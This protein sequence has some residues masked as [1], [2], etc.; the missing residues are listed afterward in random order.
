MSLPIIEV[1]KYSVTIPSTGDK[2]QYRP[3][4]VKEEKILMIAMESESQE[5]M[6][7][8]IRDIIDACTFNTLDIDSLSTFDLEYIFLKLRAKSVGEV[9]TVGLK[10]SSCSEVNEIDINLDAIEVSFPE[11]APKNGVVM[12]ND[13]IGIRFRYPTVANS[14]KIKDSNTIEGI[15]KLITLCIDNIFDAEN[16]YPASNST[17]KELMAFLESLNTEQFARIQ[18]FFE[19]MPSISYETKFACEHCSHENTLVLKGLANFFG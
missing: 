1:P 16:V 9:S 12:I 14:T 3:Y 13:K 17:P 8:A 6:L 18:N 4:L 7:T 5:Q 15:M 19:K 11:D 2:I 10:C